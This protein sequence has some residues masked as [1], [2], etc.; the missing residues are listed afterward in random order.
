MHGE[1]FIG[2][3]WFLFFEERNKENFDNRKKT[4]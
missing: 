4:V 2:S 1:F 3:L